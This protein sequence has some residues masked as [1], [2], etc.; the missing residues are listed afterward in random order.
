MFGKLNKKL[1]K[2]EQEAKKRSDGHFTIMKFTTGYKVL[3]GTPDLTDYRQKLQLLD[4][5][6]YLEDALENALEEKNSFIENE[7]TE[8][9]NENEETN[10]FDFIKLSEIK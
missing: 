10:P 7:E 9:C 6:K 1:K 2:L 5:F 4:G 3:F 8:P